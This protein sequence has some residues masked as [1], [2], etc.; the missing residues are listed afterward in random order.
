MNKRKYSPEISNF[1]GFDEFQDDN[2]EPSNKRLH[3]DDENICFICLETC[4]R[5]NECCQQYVCDECEKRWINTSGKCGHC[6]RTLKRKRE[7]IEQYEHHNN[8]TENIGIHNYSFALNPEELQPS[9]SIN[10]TRYSNVSVELHIPEQ[11][12]ET[13]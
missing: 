9:G 4:D 6:R 2:L 7:D 13:E 10:L 12:D 3:I 5:Q 11:S 8:I 1:C